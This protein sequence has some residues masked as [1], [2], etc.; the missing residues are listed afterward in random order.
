MKFCQSCSMPLD[1]DPQGGG[2]N[3]D[4]SRSTRYCSLCYREGRFT[5]PNF[6]V[7]DMQ[8]FCIAQLRKRGMPSVM[9]WIFT[10]SLPGLE[11]WRR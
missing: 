10:R 8:D 1:R 11:R 6:T 4:G 5:Q 9:G 3:A 7:K 2:G